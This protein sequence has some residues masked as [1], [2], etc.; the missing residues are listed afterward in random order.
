[1]DEPRTLWE[2]KIIELERGFSVET[3]ATINGLSLN[4]FGKNDRKIVI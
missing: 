1:M 4:T 3:I 2:S